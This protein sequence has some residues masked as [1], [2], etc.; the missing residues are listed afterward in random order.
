MTKW[1]MKLSQVAGMTETETWQSMTV[2]PNQGARA[3]SEGVG[4][5]IGCNIS[6]NKVSF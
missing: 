4:V 3:A 5:V 1:R 6:F 2:S